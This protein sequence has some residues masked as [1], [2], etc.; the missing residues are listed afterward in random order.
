M[1]SNM[2]NPDEETERNWDLELAEDVKGEVEGKYGRIAR[3][4][5]DKMSQGDVYMEFKDIEGAESAHRGLSGR[6]FGGKQL[7]AQYINESLFNQHV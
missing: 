3:I 1:V 6:F 2:F 5:V 7:V 4:K